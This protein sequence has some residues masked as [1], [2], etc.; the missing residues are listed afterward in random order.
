MA[1]SCNRTGS[2]LVSLKK[3][4]LAMASA[5]GNFDFEMWNAF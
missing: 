2:T 4:G 5:A 3:L 1:V